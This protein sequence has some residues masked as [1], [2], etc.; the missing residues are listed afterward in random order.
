MTLPAY[1][2]L[3][4]KIDY[5]SDQINSAC[6]N[7]VGDTLLLATHKQLKLQYQKP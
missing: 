6:C 1:S 3:L 5:L 7:F 2:T 4:Q